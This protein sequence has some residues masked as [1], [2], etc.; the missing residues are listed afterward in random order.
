ME[1]RNTD[2]RYELLM[3]SSGGSVSH[4]SVSLTNITDYAS[5]K[6]GFVAVVIFFCLFSVLVFF[7]I[8]GFL[9]ART[10]GRN[11]FASSNNQK[12]SAVPTNNALYQKHNDK[13][14]VTPEDYMDEDDCF[15]A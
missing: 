2:E 8:F 14:L 7:V 15:T 10:H 9:Q 3:V 4:S 1:D 12:Y 5:T 6:H 11:C 13:V